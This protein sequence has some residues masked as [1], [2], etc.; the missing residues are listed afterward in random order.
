M[1][2]LV[3]AAAEDIEELRR[4]DTA[5]VFHEGLGID[6]ARLHATAVWRR[7][8]L[9]FESLQAVLPVRADSSP[10]CIYPLYQQMVRLFSVL[11]LCRVEGVGRT[12][13][14]A[15]FGQHLP[16]WI[17]EQRSR[18]LAKIL[19]KCMSSDDLASVERAG[20]SGGISNLCYILHEMIRA[21]TVR[22][23]SS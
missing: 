11:K 13:L 19:P 2:K 15:V 10:R 8:S 23:R 5:R 1:I 20:N 9:D 7:L 4:S 3:V 16:G 18:C 22:V 14:E 17:Q 12:Q 21:Y 6:M